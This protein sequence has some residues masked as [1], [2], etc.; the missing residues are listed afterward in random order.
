MRHLITVLSR[1]LC[2]FSLILIGLPF[3]A[4]AESLQI[5]A[6]AK[7]GDFS[8]FSRCADQ[9]AYGEKS[10]FAECGTLYVAENRA[11]PAG[12][13]LAL[14]VV[15]LAASDGDGRHPIIQLNGGPGGT[16]L[17]HPI[18]SQEFLKK[19]DILLLGYRGVDDLQPLDCP[20]VK[21]A[22]SLPSP[23][24]AGTRKAMAE[25]AQACASRLQA[26]GLDLSQYRMEDVI[27]DF[28]VLRRALGLER[29]NLLSVSYGTRIAQYYARL[30]P[31]SVARSVQIAV[32]PPGH[33]Q[34]LPRI[35]HDIMLQYGKLCAQDE[36]CNTRTKDLTN[37]TL[38][39]LSRDNLSWNGHDIDMDRIRIVAFIM[40]M[41][42]HSAVQLF[43]AVLDAR[44]G[45]TKALHEL[46]GIYDQ[47][48][49]E[50]VWG[51]L[52][53]K[54]GVD[55][56]GTDLEEFS[57]PRMTTRQQL[58]SPLDLVYSSGVTSWPIQ[59]APAGFNQAAIDLTETLLIN[60]N[61]DMSTP[62]EPIADELLK[63]LP[64]GRLVVLKDYGHNDVRQAEATEEL[65][66]LLMGFLERGAVDST[67]VKF[68]AVNF[69]AQSGY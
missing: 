44:G 29:F 5:P 62:L 28:E 3:Y 24:S 40:L 35:N 46:V 48:V 69:R 1:G 33:F 37:D 6:S 56:V 54:G 8:G 52:Y 50:T 58:G 60:G 41:N 67:A 47:M 19:Y 10:Q 61:L 14:P 36:Y 25:A 38:A 65:G 2:T 21:Q 4:Q 13:L 7:P 63:F 27:G 39:I 15:R 34:W 26:Q 32:N 49:Q 17:F 51:D 22:A 30:H 20:E 55:Y 57:A 9:K 42:K 16:N 53:S 11:R 23:L 68:R 31:S 64:N 43:N 18:K 59:A 45:D 12:R 66:A